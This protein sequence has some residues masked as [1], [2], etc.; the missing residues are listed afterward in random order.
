MINLKVLH[1]MIY[2]SNMT[3]RE[4]FE[5][6][7]DLTTNL[8]GLQQGSL[9]FRTRKQ[10]ILVP[11]MVASVIAIIAKDIHPETIA[12][13]IKKDRTSVIHYR[14]THKHNY[15]SFPVY[16]EVFN[17]VYNA[18]LEQEKFKLVFKNRD[19]LIRHLIDAGI[20]TTIKSQVKIKVKCR[21]IKHFVHTNYLD[22][23]NNIDIINESLKDYD[24][25]IDIITT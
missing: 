11:R 25:S 4:K 1:L 16:R 6:L 13:I 5:S 2:H 7:C 22:F 17:K 3:D 15:Q 9:S 12:D 19:D 23:S 18:Y 20:K 21:N 8:V 14:K 24:Y 10:E